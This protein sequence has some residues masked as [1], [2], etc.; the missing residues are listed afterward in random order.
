VVTAVVPAVVPVVAP[1]VVPAGFPVEVPAAAPAVVLALTPAVA[2]AV[3]PAVAP[4][5]VPAVGPVISQPLTL[6]HPA[7]PAPTTGSA[8]PAE[9]TSLEVAASAVEPVTREHTTAVVSDSD[10]ASGYYDGDSSDDDDD[11][12]PHQPEDS[13]TCS[14][15]F[16]AEQWAKMH[17][18]LAA[19]STTV[20]TK[21]AY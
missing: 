10:S 5:V 6:Q 14:E 8:N 17:A 20:L 16:G 11:D 12:A 1:A 4:A 15:W 18:H 19:Q 3:A 7:T 9:G 21:E 2:L 13:E